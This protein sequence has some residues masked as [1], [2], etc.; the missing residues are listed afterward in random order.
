MSS[1]PV[2]YYFQ[3]TYTGSVRM[4]AIKQTLHETQLYLVRS[5]DHI[6]AELYAGNEFAIIK[7]PDHSLKVS[8]WK[9]DHKKKVYAI[10]DAF[11]GEAVGKVEY[12]A[13]FWTRKIIANALLMVPGEIYSMK[14]IRTPVPLFSPKN[15]RVLRYQM[16]SGGNDT[17]YYTGK[18][19]H[20]DKHLSKG[21]KEEIFSGT[22]EAPGYE[23]LFPAMTGL[24]IL[25]KNFRLESKTSAV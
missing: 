19:S 22:I 3:R 25:E 10:T 16:L 14:K 5:G 17:Y 8:V 20:T 15:K 18:F 9:K 7:L 1:T 23:H 24:Y 4:E 11:T 2:L 6:I 13:W 21:H 12:P